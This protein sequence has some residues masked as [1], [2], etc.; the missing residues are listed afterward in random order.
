MIPLT[1]SNPYL[2]D[3]EAVRRMLERNALDSSMFEGARGLKQ[4][5]AQ[6]Q[7]EAPRPSDRRRSSMQAE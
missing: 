6:L 5:A 7:P 3:P 2:R 4:S 1:Q